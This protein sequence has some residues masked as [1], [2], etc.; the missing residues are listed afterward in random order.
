MVAKVT[1]Q[2]KT[3]FVGEDNEIHNVPEY[4][5]LPSEDKRKL[6]FFLIIG[7]ENGFTVKSDGREPVIVTENCEALILPAGT[8]I[9]PLL[10]K[11]SRRER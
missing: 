7:N 8:R 4:D 3:F 2:G 5:G 9:E 11:P 1:S 10:Q 6:A